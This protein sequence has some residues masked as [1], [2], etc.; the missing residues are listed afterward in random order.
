MF[1]LPSFNRLWCRQHSPLC[2][3]IATPCYPVCPSSLPSLSICTSSSKLIL[4][5][6][7][8]TVFSSNHNDRSTLP[9]T[10]HSS[11]NVASTSPHRVSRQVSYSSQARWRNWLSISAHL[12]LRSGHVSELTSCQWHRSV[13]SNRR[14]KSKNRLEVDDSGGVVMAKLPVMDQNCQQDEMMFQFI[15]VAQYATICMK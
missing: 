2:I 8:L 12:F 14:G 1:S 4:P 10:H 5:S 3:F 9:L 7:G 11:L 13:S 6:T 15:L